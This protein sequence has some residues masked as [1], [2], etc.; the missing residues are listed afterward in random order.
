MH[1]VKKPVWEGCSMCGSG[2]V[3]ASRRQG[4]GQEGDEGELA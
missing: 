4:L 1:I 3:T 2:H